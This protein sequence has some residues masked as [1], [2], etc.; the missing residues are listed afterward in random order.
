MWTTLIIKTTKN[1]NGSHKHI[2]ENM[3]EKSLNYLKTPT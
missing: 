2:Q 3:Y 1:T